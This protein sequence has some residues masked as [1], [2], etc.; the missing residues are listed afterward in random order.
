MSGQV[1]EEM[2]LNGPTIPNEAS[3]QVG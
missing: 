2:K 1:D 3:S